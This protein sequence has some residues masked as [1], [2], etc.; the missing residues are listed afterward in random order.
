[1]R[2]GLA[3]AVAAARRALD[4]RGQRPAVV[5]HDVWLA[6]GL[7]AALPETAL[8]CISASDTIDVYRDRGIEIFCLSEQVGGHATAGMSSLELLQH[9]ATR[10]FFERLGPTAVLAFKP[11]E[12]IAAAVGDLGG[13]LLSAPAS[14]ARRYENK[15]EFVA[16]AERAGV[17]R[18]FWVVR[19]LPPG[20]AELEAQFGPRV[21]V[22]GARG[23]A[24]QRTW[25]VSDQQSLDYARQREGSGAVRA[26]EFVEGLPF[27]ATGVALGGTGSGID[28]G[29]P[30][31]TIEPC[32]Q[33]TGVGWLTP[34]QLGSCGNAWDPRLFEAHRVEI[35]RCMHALGA[36]LAANN[37]RGVY[38]VDFVLADDGPL[39]IE[40]NPR[41]VASI[42]VASELE[43]EA[44]RAPLVLLHLLEL[45]NAE[46][47][48]TDA[49]VPAGMEL[50]AGS[51]LILHRLD[52]DSDVPPR[53]GVYRVGDGGDVD[54]LRPGANMADLAAPGEL[55][56]MTRRAGEP[57][58]RRKEFGRIYSRSGDGEHAPGVRELVDF[59]RHGS[60]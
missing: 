41:M 25:M 33:V 30:P 46:F 21:V 5:A 17:P 20:F 59:A 49:Q 38:G 54:F 31:A 6:A 24:G 2:P 44:G 58:S 8:V 4:R 57:V 40:V 55:L 13:E 52:G 7:A 34:E 9:P 51:L 18:P 16:A 45:S 36:D 11:S 28:G 56:L 12:R 39:V 10:A 53:N 26:A 29:R 1:M 14:A 22:Q 15:L 35:G 27:T 19:P 23:N 3:E 50:G 43:V 32:R 47:P 60:A 48:R 37:Y 42:P